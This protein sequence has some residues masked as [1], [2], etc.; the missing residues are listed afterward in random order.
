MSIH[1]VILTSNTGQKNENIVVNSIAPIKPSCKEISVSIDLT[2]VKTEE[3]NSSLP[4]PRLIRRQREKGSFNELLPHSYSA[5]I[6]GDIIHDNGCHRKEEPKE[7]VHDIGCKHGALE[8]HHTD[9]HDRP[10]YLY[11]CIYTYIHVY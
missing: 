11:K 9:S 1:F 6:S 2:L 3:K 10:K 4:H 5:E 8:H 7:S